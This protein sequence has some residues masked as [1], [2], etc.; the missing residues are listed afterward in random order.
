VAA[1]KQR[2]TQARSDASTRLVSKRNKAAAAGPRGRCG[3]VRLGWRLVH[4]RIRK[5]LSSLCLPPSSLID[6]KAPPPRVLPRRPWSRWRLQ[7][8]RWAQP[9]HQVAEGL[10]F[11]ISDPALEAR[12][13]ARRCAWSNSTTEMRRRA[14]ASPR[15]L[16]LTLH[17]SMT[18]M[19]LT[20]AG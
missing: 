6:P 2:R 20:T 11:S 14:P 18:P 5:L 19:V 17:P 4:G 3:E 13:A 16:H 7:V 10:V 1:G 8:A 9:Q 15:E 12:V